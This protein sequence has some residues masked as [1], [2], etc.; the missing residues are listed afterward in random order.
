MI[1]KMRL[2][3]ANQPVPAILPSKPNWTEMNRVIT[4]QT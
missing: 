1:D 2:Q 3:I 4:K